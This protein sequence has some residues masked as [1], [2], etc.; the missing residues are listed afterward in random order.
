MRKQIRNKI[1]CTLDDQGKFAEFAEKKADPKA[2][3]R[4][5]TPAYQL[6]PPKKNSFI[7]Y[8]ERQ[9]I[10]TKGEIDS[11]GSENTE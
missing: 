3:K 11:G 2:L 4:F 7:E 9:G 6:K 10:N 1:Q 8:L 5:K